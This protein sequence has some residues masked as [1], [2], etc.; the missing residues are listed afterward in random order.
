MVEDISVQEAPE[1][2]KADRGT[3]TDKVPPSPSK[4][5]LRKKIRRLQMTVQRRN[6]KIS[7]ITDL[8]SHLK[9]KG[10]LNND[11]ESIL[12][13]HFSGFPL[14]FIMN[15]FQNSEVDKPARSYSDIMKQFALTLHFHS[16]KAYK[17]VRTLFPLPHPNRI[18]SWISSVN[19]E[20]GF[21]SEV[22]Q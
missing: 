12:K 3:Q 14:H 4:T 17:Y 15:Q 20:P 16:P 5:E 7:S 8:I 22:F 2:N 13:F 11:L 19:C 6:K 10:H 21:V 18:R 1:C 9:K